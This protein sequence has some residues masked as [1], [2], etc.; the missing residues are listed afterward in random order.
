MPQ[1]S[2]NLTN[3]IESDENYLRMLIT[4]FLD[5]QTIRI[6]GGDT[7]D[8]IFNNQ[9]FYSVNVSRSDIRINGNGDI[10][11]LTLTIEDTDSRIA[12]YIALNGNK[13]NNR[14]C[15]IQ[16]VDIRYLINEADALTIFD[17][18][19]NN[20]KL[21]IGKY[22]VDVVRN[23]CTHK[24]YSPIM[25]YSP[26]CQWKKFKDEKCAYTG[27]SNKCDRTLTTCKSL[28]NVLNFGG[29]PSIPSEMTIR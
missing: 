22:Q 27:A 29:H 17:G 2:E 21:T 23:L 10:D 6:C 20:L 5:D 19:M 8:L 14:R 7:S 16:E 3:A 11:D 24:N 1:I 28:G 15:L 9:T 26:T 18:F 25:T 12:S 13:I 4:I